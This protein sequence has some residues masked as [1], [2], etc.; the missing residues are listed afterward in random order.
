[1][2]VILCGTVFLVLQSIINACLNAQG[3]TKSYRNVLIMGFVLNCI[4]DPWFLYGGLGVPPMGIKGIALA[5][6]LIQFSECS[7]PTSLLQD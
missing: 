6:V 2:N 4:L 7:P 3:D 5:T 1:M